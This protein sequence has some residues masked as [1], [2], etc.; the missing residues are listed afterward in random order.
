LRE[1]NETWRRARKGSEEGGKPMKFWNYKRQVPRDRNRGQVG[2]GS[3]GA[4]GGSETLIKVQWSKKIKGCKGRKVTEKKRRAGAVGT[5][6][7]RGR[8]PL[9]VRGKVC[10]KDIKMNKRRGKHSLRSTRKGCEG[11]ERRN[12]HS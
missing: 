12:G 9:E 8:K 6:G 3:V 2:G 1:K 5:D 10:G 11:G 7:G 4:S